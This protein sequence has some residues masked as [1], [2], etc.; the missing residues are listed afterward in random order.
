MTKCSQAFDLDNAPGFR[1]CSELIFEV[2]RG[3]L[4]WPRSLAPWMF[5]D[6]LGSGPFE[7]IT[8]LQEYYLTRTENGGCGIDGER[9]ALDFDPARA[10]RAR[11]LNAGARAPA[12]FRWASSRRSSQ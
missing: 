5:Y 6:E 9:L 10:G 12:D 7:R 3:L 1:A 4:T 11:W 8:V 2:Q